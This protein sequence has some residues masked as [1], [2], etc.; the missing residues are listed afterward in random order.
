M[1]TSSSSEFYSPSFTVLLERADSLE[2]ISLSSQYVSY[3]ISREKDKIDEFSLFHS[4][5]HHI[6]GFI[7]EG[8]LI[9][10]V[11]HIMLKLQTNLSD[12]VLFSNYDSV[13]NTKR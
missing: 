12:C 8:R 3:L 9:I 5:R 13:P 10:N 1:I 6:A 4:P 7:T 2:P 11:F